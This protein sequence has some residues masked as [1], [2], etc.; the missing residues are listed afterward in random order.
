MAAAGG[1]EGWAVL[2][3]YRILSLGQG[4]LEGERPG[5]R[6]STGGT[7]RIDGLYP[8]PVIY[9]VMQLYRRNPEDLD[10]RNLHNEGVQEGFLVV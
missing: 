1:L 7:Q 10:V 4:Q 6:E 5:R 2:L 8:P 9:L 3:G